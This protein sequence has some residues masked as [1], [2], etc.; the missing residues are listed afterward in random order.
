MKRILPA[1]AACLL[2]FVSNHS[3][4]QRKGSAAEPI[5]SELFDGLKFRSIGPAFMSGRIADLAIDPTNENVWYVAVGSGGVWKTVN[6][7]T[8]FK[9]IFDKQSVYSIG[10]VSLDPNNPYTVWVG[11]GENVGGR[12]AG[13]GDGIYRSQDGGETWENMGLENSEHISKIIVHPENSDVIMVASQGPL[14]S[15]GGDR[16]FF[17]SID[18]G[19]SWKKTLGDNEF[20]G[21]TDMVYDPRDPNRIYAVTWQHH[22]TVA[23]WMGG[24]KKSRLYVSNDAGDSWTQLK[25]GLPEGNWGKTGL[26]I[27][28]QNPDVLY[29]AIE[30][31]QRTGG[32]W[33]SENRGGS[34]TKMSDAVA[35]ATGPHYYQ[36]IF[37][38][39]H[40]FDRLYLMNNRLMK[41]EDGG[42][43]FANMDETAKHGDN[44]AVAFKASDPNY[45]LVGTD[46]GLYE[47]FDLGATWRFMQNLPLTQFYKLA[48]DDAEPFYNIYGGTQDNS[49]EGGPSRTDNH[50]G[51]R[52][53]DWKVVLNWDGHQPATEPGN[54]DI[55][56]GQRQEGTLSR[57]DL[58]SG[59]VID[60]MPQAGA[61]EDYERYNWD[62]PILVSPHSPSTIYH[63]SQRLW[64]STDRGD[65]W[66]TLSGDLTRGQERM[67]L[68]IMGGTQSWDSPW[69]LLAMS[70]FNTITSIAVSP[71]NEKVIFIGT[72][73]GLI[74]VT[75]DEG[76]NWKKIEVSKLGVPSRCY[77]NDIKAD[78][79]DENTFYVALD[80][81]KEG[82]YKPYLF[83]TTD[84]GASWKRIDNGLGT[85]NLV[86]RIVQDH[87]DKD[88]MFV[89]TEFGVFV[90]IDGGQSWTEMN[91]G[92]PT[93]SFRDLAIQRRENDLVCAS[94]GRGFYVLDDYTALRK[95]NK[96]QL[97]ENASLFEP[98]RA[99]WYIEKSV[100]S[101]GGPRGSQGA[102]L[103]VAP[104][105]DFG[106]VFTYY[107]KNE[108]KSLEKLRQESEKE[109]NTNI[110]FTGWEAIEDEAREI[111]PFV[112]LEIK[113]ESGAV[114]N[115]IKATNK[116]GFNRVAWNLRVGGSGTLML[117]KKNQKLTA[118]LAAPGNYTATLFAFEQGK[119]TQLGQPVKVLVERLGETA[120]PGAPIEEVATFW[121]KYEQMTREVNTL[122][123]QLAT[124]RKVSDKLLLA[125][126]STNVNAGVLERIAKLKSELDA[127]DSQLNGNPAKVQV[128][129]KVKPNIGDRLFALNRGISLSTHGPTATHLQTVAII[130]SEFESMNNEL[131]KL[132]AEAQQIA[133][134]IKDAGGPWIEGLE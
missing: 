48:V 101:F 61:N 20:T 82:D 97:A 117:D 75:S 18:G 28:S 93:I 74:Q 72:D 41:S 85:K 3:H 47:S 13:F 36:E 120:L 49:T 21:V 121:R 113:D 130:E 99:W 56:Y 23:S 77:V 89:G 112:Y 76:K 42:K 45:L 94:F 4:A 86:W 59:E 46:G 52:N 109:N 106:A 51:I 90:T 111:K 25:T 81:H 92:I 60:I 39:P 118:L 129:E 38:S 34:W 65:S 80:N 22:R 68:P 54:P 124:T 107:L 1:I 116:A 132:R 10:C 84:K 63:G 58:K 83:K 87:E 100:L 123:S 79:I 67:A 11:T 12:H 50:H 16:G 128:G 53:A 105:P 8:T 17:K 37:A 29:A 62:A 126:Q 43:T 40:K 103:F 64:K 78:L 33:R 69:D 115:R 30:L 71:K 66:V 125:A 131:I 14:W 91:G 70:N 24:G 119:A 102:Q 32:V 26:A 114:V 122:K 27:S 15:A 35:G 127:I 2:L 6:A 55:M 44:H 110:S 31:N 19:K 73:D 88:L 96:T 133:A 134:I 98:R 9:P 108:F 57:I 95:V 104:N 5:K 7:G